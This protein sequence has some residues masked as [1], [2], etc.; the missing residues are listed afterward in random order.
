[1]SGEERGE[2]KKTG[3]ERTNEEKRRMKEEM[4]GEE[5]KK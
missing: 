4:C 5:W 1:M 3:V 2:A